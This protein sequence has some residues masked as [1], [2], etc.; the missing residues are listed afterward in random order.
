[1]FLTH[2]AF[3][4]FIQVFFPNHQ[5]IRI[6]IHFENLKKSDSLYQDLSK[7]FFSLG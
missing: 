2:Q 4:E 5:M 1:M 6:Y 7:D 3:K